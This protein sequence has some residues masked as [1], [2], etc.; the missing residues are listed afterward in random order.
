MATFSIAGVQ[1]PVPIGGQNTQAMLERA[2][3]AVHLYP[4]V[5]MLLFSEL[6]LHGP[7]LSFTADDTTAIESPFRDFAAKHGIWICPGSYFLRRGDQIFNHAVVIDPTGEVVGRYDK[8]FP[9]QPYEQN[10]SAGDRFLLFDIPEVGRF[11]LSICYDIWFP[12]TTR[13]LVSNGAEVLLHPVLTG[14]T[15]RD[16]ELAIARA[17]AAMFQCYVVDVNGLSAGGIGKSLICDPTGL[18]VHSAGELDC[19]FPITLDLDLVRRT[20]LRGTNGLGQPLKS[21]R[22][23]AVKFDVYR[24]ESCTSYLDS[25]G[26]LHMP[27]RRA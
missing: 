17:T 5:D 13:S 4:W 3:K 16:A 22:D 20:R 14:T 27:P 8:M 26:P 18:I 2:M 19:I 11:G 15:D 21:F 1:M 7:S 6:A 10:V 12:E 9:F 23:S 24:H 25:L